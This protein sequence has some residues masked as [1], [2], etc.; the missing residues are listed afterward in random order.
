[1]A[2][3]IETTVAMQYSLKVSKYLGIVDLDMVVLTFKVGICRHAKYF[4]DFRTN[5]ISYKVLH[6]MYLYT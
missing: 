6:E 5:Y 3:K 2:M 1:M 4:F